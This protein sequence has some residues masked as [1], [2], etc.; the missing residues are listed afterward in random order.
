MDCGGHASRNL[1]FLSFHHLHSTDM[2]SFLKKIKFP[3]IPSKKA[4]RKGSRPGQGV[5]GGTTPADKVPEPDITEEKTRSERFEEENRR[6]RDNADELAEANRKLEEELRQVKQRLE[7][8]E[9]ELADKNARLQRLEKHTS[10]LREKVG[11]VESGM[12]FNS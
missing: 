9:K 6:I 7:A 8:Q 10:E 12:D 5:K 2:P 4:A 11:R 3:C 1:I